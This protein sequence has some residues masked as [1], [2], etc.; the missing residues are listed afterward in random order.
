[1]SDLYLFRNALKDLTRPKRL[2]TAAILILL[3]VLI[4]LLWRTSAADFKAEAAYNTLSAGLVFG[5][6]LVILSVIFSTDIIA[7]EI[8]QKT[9]VYL[10]TRPV[11]RWRIILTK[12]AAAILMTTLTV[13]VA[14]FLLAFATYGLHGLDESRLGRDLLI[15]PV[16]ALAYGGFFLLLATFLNRPLM[17]GLLFAFGWESWVP[18]LPGNFQK[19]SL[20]AYLR[21]LAPH[22]KPQA[23]SVDISDLLSSLNPQTISSPLAWQV[24]TGVILV[25]VGIALFLF[26][27]NEYVPREDAE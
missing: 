26:S 1:M 5:F 12:F 19:M 8:E 4:A 22:P 25:T 27:T 15:L 20:M 16:G 9:I 18:N 17:Y 2:I 24:L 21:V 10:L 3:P 7:Q 11:P 6:I 14:S 23:E 13:W